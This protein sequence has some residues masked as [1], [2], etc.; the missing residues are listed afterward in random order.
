MTTAFKQ[1]QRKRRHHRI[2]AK[3][4]G[5]SSRPRLV[6]FRSLQHISAQLIDDSQGKTIA[7]SSS[8]KM[9]GTPAHLA[10][11][12]GLALAERAQTAKI[13]ACVFDRNGYLYHGRVK[14]L[15]EAAREAGLQF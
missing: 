2:R 8:L 12:V 5:T 7:S 3:I 10:K 1:Q 13:T 9:K 6:V 11:E 15:A 14:I 4:V